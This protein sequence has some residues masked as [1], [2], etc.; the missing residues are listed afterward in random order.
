MIIWY[1]ITIFIYFS[2]KCPSMTILYEYHIVILKY[3]MRSK[4]ASPPPRQDRYSKGAKSRSG[5]LKNEVWTVEK[6]G[7]EGPKSRSGGSKIEA[8]KS[9]GRPLEQL[10]AVEPILR[11]C[12]RRPGG[13]LGASWRA[14]RLSLGRLGVVLE[15][16]EAIQVRRGA[17]NGSKMRHSVLH[18][19]C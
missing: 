8:W 3:P 18:V 5:G 15:A 12:Q 19:M 11:V 14:W 2:G 16:P 6:R 17:S 9:S 1:Y 10:G 7:L 4:A 13:A